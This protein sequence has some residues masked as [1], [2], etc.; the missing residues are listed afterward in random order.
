MKNFN[1]TNS[2]N[3]SWYGI[4]FNSGDNNVSNNC[5]G[6]SSGT[7]S[8]IFTTGSS[9]GGFTGIIQ[10]VYCSSTVNNN[11]IG[12]ITVA[13][14]NAAYATNF[15]GIWVSSYCGSGSTSNNLVGSATTS[16]SIN[17]T[18]VSTSNAQTVVGIKIQGGSTMNISNNTIANLTNGT[19]NA[20]TSTQGYIYGIYPFQGVNTITGNTIHDLTI[21]N[22]NNGTGPVISTGVPSTSLSAGGIVAPIY[23]GSNQTISG[24]TVYN[25]SNSRTDFTGHVA[26]IYHYGQSSASSVNANIIY[27][28]SV[29]SSS[30]SA[31]IHGIK[32]GQGT[33]TYSNNIIVLGVT[34]QP[35]SMEFMKQGRPVRRAICILIPFTLLV[36][37]LQVL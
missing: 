19:T 1:F 22:A 8:I 34:P 23:N 35:I 12:A 16:N 3:Y 11:T 31:S 21:A 9:D 17:A 15:L 33:T 13:N 27:G 18:S 29:N 14:S 25:I 30:S 28:L 4:N 32:I 10:G 37:P 26:G 7:G 2:E 6:S 20:T 36:H 5:I 24:N